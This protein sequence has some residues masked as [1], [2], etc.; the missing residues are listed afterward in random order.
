MTPEARRL[1]I[2]ASV[3]RYPGPTPKTWVPGINMREWLGLDLETAEFT[4]LLRP[5][6]EKEMWRR[7]IN[8]RP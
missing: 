4:G 1:A 2:L 3:K 7:K 5:E 6:I 8:G